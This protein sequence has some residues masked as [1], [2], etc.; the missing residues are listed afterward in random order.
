M[1]SLAD[2]LGGKSFE[3]SDEVQAVRDYVRQ[4]YKSEAVVK[5]QRGA[6]IL[7]VPSP[8]LAATLQLE[9][10]KISQKCKLTKKLIIRIGRS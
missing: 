6:L 2:I 9:R 7:S 1:D 3:Q 5:L 8:G 10:E 4:N